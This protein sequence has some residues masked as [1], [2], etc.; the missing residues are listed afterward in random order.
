MEADEEGTVLS[1]G[2]ICPEMRY[3]VPSGNRMN[4]LDFMG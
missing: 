3:Q 2:Y 1:C 4:V